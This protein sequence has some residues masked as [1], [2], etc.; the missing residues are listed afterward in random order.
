MVLLDNF[1]TA[2]LHSEFFNYLQGPFHDH[3]VEFALFDKVENPEL[4]FKELDEWAYDNVIIMAPSVKESQ[5]SKDLDLKE[6]I[7]FFKAK[8]HN[9]MIFAGID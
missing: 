4:S 5:I 7:N 3:E 1:A 2:E 8:D 9:M 6:V